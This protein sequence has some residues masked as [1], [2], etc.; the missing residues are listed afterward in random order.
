MGRG[1]HPIALAPGMGITYN[2]GG[3]GVDWQTVSGAVFVWGAVSL[4][5]TANGLAIG[6][7]AFDALKILKRGRPRSRLWVHALAYL[8]A[9]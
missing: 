4:V 8:S 9:G 1:I 5:L 2:G 3:M 7:I 6:V